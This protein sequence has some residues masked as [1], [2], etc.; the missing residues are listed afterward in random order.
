MRPRPGT[1]RPYARCF[2]NLEAEYAATPLLLKFDGRQFVDA[3]FNEK[4][5]CHVYCSSRNIC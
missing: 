5:F 3:V 2:V 4:E 1:T